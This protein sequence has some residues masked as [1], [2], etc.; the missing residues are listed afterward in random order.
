MT[1]KGIDC[2]QPL[3]ADKAKQ[4]F[5]AGYLFAARYLVPSAYKWKRLTRAEAEAITAAGMQIVSVFETTANRPAGGAANGKPDGT[6]AFQEAVAIGQPKG[7]AIYFTVDY[8]AQPK[9][10]DAIE[11]YLRAAAAEIGDYCVGV[12]GSHKVI[13]EMYKRGAAKHFWQTYAWSSGKR[14]ARMNIWQ[15]KNGVTLADHPLDLNESYGNEGWWNTKPPVVLPKLPD[16]SKAKP[17]NVTANGSPVSNGFEVDG[18]SYIPV[19]AVAETL[20]AKVAWDQ[21]TSTV[22]ITK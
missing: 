15:H 18:V 8:D 17:V 13:E 4:L 21:A 16:L 6:A 1:T 5:A 9:D 20:G 3:N 11:R 12:Y 7:T 19:R 2:A 14:S 22:K 10:Y